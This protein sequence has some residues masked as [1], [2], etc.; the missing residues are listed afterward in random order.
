MGFAL[1]TLSGCGKGEKPVDPASPESYMKDEAFRKALKDRRAVAQEIGVRR[2]QVTARQNEMVKIM[3]E[4]LQTSDRAKIVAELSKNAEWQS[5]E[6][7]AK[8]IDEEF[9]KHH[10]E[11]M[12]L[13]HKR[14]APRGAKPD[15]K[16]SK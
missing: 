3:G 7:K 8:A 5:L 12:R 1:L 14:I 2:E 4:K 13:V 10:R 9:M 16:I 6:A 11:T 15:G